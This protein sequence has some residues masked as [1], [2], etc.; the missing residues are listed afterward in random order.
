MQTRN[1]WAI[2]CTPTIYDALGACTQLDELTWNVDRGNPRPGDRV[3][4][5]QGKASNRD[6]GVVGIG[7]I[8]EGPASIS[9]GPEERRFYRESASFGNPKVRIRLIHAPGLPLWLSAQP[10]FLASLSVARGRGHTLFDLKLEQ[11]RKICEL[12]ETKE[13]TTLLS[14]RRG[15]GWLTD[16]KKRKV[17]ELF[18]Q[19]RAEEHFID[20]GFEAEDV[21]HTQPYD[22]LCRKGTQQLHVEA[23]GAMGGADTVILTRN[24]VA[25]CRSGSDRSVL[26]VV[27]DIEVFEED[28]VLQARGGV[29]HV[30][31]P[32]SIDDQALTPLQYEYRL[33]IQ[34]NLVSSAL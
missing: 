23:K 26:V 9:E 25:H 4:I 17:V 14:S 8:S 11:W 22:L 12:V 15:Q 33:P 10:D 1:Y 27:S 2:L 21:H 31:Q 18:A 5:W 20:Q 24:E 13:A 7:V 3:V 34:K 30:F 16:P 19:A 6:R 32:W 28:G 29:L